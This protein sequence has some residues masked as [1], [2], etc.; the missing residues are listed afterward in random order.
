[1]AMKNILIEFFF[2]YFHN[3]AQHEKYIHWDGYKKRK[4]VEAMQFNKLL[5]VRRVKDSMGL[6]SGTRIEK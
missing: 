2:F 5:D 6:H 3:K 4:T 1:M